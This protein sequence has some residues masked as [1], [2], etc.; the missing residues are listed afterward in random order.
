MCIEAKSARYWKYSPAD[1]LTHFSPSSNFQP[2]R[3][4]LASGLSFINT[5]CTRSER[6]LPIM[7]ENNKNHHITL[8]KGRIVL[9]CLDVVDRDDSKYQIRSPD[10][11]KKAIIATDERYNDCFLLQSTVPAQSKDEFLQIIYTTED[12][13]LHQPISNGNCISADARM[14]KGFADFLSERISD[15]RSNCGKVKL[16]VGQVYPLWDPTGKRFIYNLANKEKLCDKTN[17]SI[18]LKTLE[19]M[20]IHAN[21]TGVSTIA[22]PKRGCGL[23]QMKKQELVKSVRVFFGHA[24]VQIAV[25]TLEKNGV[26]AMSAESEAEFYADDEIER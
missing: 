22:I 19:A 6:S 23:D 21:T 9:S 24:D 8:P 7:M 17:L 18:P 13:I 25:Y 16:F 14:S 20:K 26:Y 11:L 12:S 2:N 10:E 3:N 4:A 15:L 5:V 1:T